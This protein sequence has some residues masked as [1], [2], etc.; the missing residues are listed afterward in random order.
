MA[1]HSYRF[2]NSILIVASNFLFNLHQ[3]VYKYS[4]FNSQTNVQSLHVIYTDLYITLKFSNDQ[5][6]IIHEKFNNCLES[7]KE[8][9]IWY[10]PMGN[11]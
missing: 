9:S 8:K 3:H 1:W 4:F 6:A 5:V 7:I 10:V 11:S 2:L